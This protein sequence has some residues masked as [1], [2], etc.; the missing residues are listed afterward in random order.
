MFMRIMQIAKLSLLVLSAGCVS[1]PITSYKLPEKAVPVA[2]SQVFTD[3]M[4][5]QREI[6]VKIWGT[7]NPGEPVSVS[8]AGKTSTTYTGT[9]G[10]WLVQL[11][12][13]K[14]SSESRNLVIKGHNEVTLHDVLVGEV[15]LCSGQSNMECGMLRFS[16]GRRDITNSTLPMLRLFSVEKKRSNFPQSGFGPVKGWL[17]CMPGNLTQVGSDF[18][19][20]SATAFYFGRALQ[21]RLGIPVGLVQSAWGGTK[22]EPWTP[23]A[24]AGKDGCIYNAMIAPMTNLTIRGA[25]W[26]Q[27][28]SN[29][30]DGEAYEAKMKDLIGSW[31]VVFG[32]PD[33]PFY[34]VEIAPFRY[35]KTG[36]NA[37]LLG[38]LRVAQA[39]VS[40]TMPHTG[41]IHT[42]DNPDN[43]GN[44]HPDNKPQI[45]ERLARLAMARTYRA[46]VGK[47]ITGPTFMKASR[48]ADGI[49]VSFSE[50]A[51][52][53]QTIDGK[54][55]AGFE[56]LVP[57]SASSNQ[58]IA[59]RSEI[60]GDQILVQI[61][62][63]RPKGVRFCWNE[64]D[65]SNLRNAEGLPP[66]PFLTELQ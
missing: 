8:F 15:W 41:M 3:N 23:A 29:R 27:G 2:L 16:Q 12:P 63:E 24:L 61:S 55:P 14:A 60:R 6:P 39:R 1:S 22:I 34:F 4:V 47:S 52:S 51:G 65:Q 40:M 48:E 20:F 58:W 28:E 33:M 44:I 18:G 30:T 9:N 45:G 21:A 46:S 43:V 56:V 64:T 59:A 37:E 17:P 35:C 5:L 13:M 53:L 57:V 42:L 54:A 38:R 11:P 25:V 31:R 7:A 36:G 32:Q 50:T 26:Y 10:C 19:S 62:S 49:R 66:S